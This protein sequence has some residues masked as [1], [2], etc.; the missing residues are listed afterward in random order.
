M[1]ATLLVHPLLLLLQLRLAAPMAAAVSWSKIG[2]ATCSATNKHQQF[3]SDSSGGQIRDLA[4]GRCLSVLGG[5]LDLK[6]T[7]GG[8]PDDCPNAELYGEVVLDD[9]GG[10]KSTWAL[11]PGGFYKSSLSDKHAGRC[12]GLMVTQIE[13]PNIAPTGC[14]GSKGFC[15]KCTGGAMS[16]PALAKTKCQSPQLVCWP[17]PAPCTPGKNNQIINFD[18]ASG[19][20]KLGTV[21]SERVAAFCPDITNCCVTAAP[22]DA[23][24][25][26]SLVTWGATFLWLLGIG[27][28]LYVGGGIGYA[29]KYQ[30]K[31]PTGSGVSGEHHAVASLHVC[32]CFHA[33]TES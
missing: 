9:C 20:L 29:V 4:T 7:C 30:G 16:C 18:A 26:C 12:Y 32:R 15:P 5:D 3:E 13:D 22:C 19:H 17:F 21:D 14:C 25:N 27:L 33:S 11:E 10:A 24:H 8:L 2:Y 6:S 31:Q 1:R 28:T 23:E